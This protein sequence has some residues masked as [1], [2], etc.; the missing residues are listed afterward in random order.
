MAYFGK[1]ALAAA[2]VVSPTWAS[3]WWAINRH[4]V[5]PVSDG[6]YEVVGRVGSAAWDYWCGA[7]D[8]A[9]RVMGV[10]A[11]ERIYIWRGIGPSVTR[12]GRKAVQFALSPPPGADTDTPLSLSV[13]AA[14]D[15]LARH[16]A[17]WYCYQ[18]DGDEFY[19]RW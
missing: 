16:T 14:G 2:V 19:R 6:V 17:V 12:P 8:F 1:L 11:A 15:N 3:A 5:F 13:K 18:A 9:Q 4:E 7:G 10:P